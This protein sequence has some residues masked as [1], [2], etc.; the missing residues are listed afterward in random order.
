M[1]SSKWNIVMAA[2]ELGMEVVRI[3]ED[4]DGKWHILIRKRR[5]SAS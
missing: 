5:E 1:S 3:G 2:E 4:E